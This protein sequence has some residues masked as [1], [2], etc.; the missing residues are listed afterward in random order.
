MSKDVK[1]NY[2]KKH[3]LDA[4][5]RVVSKLLAHRLDVPIA[6]VLNT[7]W[8]EWKLFTSETGVY[9]KRKTWNVKDSLEGKS[10]EW[11]DLYIPLLGPMC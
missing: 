7:L 2:T 6:T 4:F 3:H 5:K 1:A 8:K 9:E 11:H 10:A